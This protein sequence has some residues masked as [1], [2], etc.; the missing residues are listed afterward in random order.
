MAKLAGFF[1]AITILSIG[2]VEVGARPAASDGATETTAAAEVAEPVDP[3]PWG[4]E[5]NLSVEIRPLDAAFNRCSVTFGERNES[6]R[7]TT[8]NTTAQGMSLG[9][10]ARFFRV[11]NWDWSAS[12]SDIT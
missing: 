12:L 5:R 10:L 8:A 9:E 11:A 2:A 4:C 1:V 6:D 7:C 3:M